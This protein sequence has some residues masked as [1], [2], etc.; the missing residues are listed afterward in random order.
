VY[1][2]SLILKSE[3]IIR[4]EAIPMSV[5]EVFEAGELIQPPDLISVES[6]ARQASY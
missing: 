4:L 5:I 6:M 3:I 2:D 1:D